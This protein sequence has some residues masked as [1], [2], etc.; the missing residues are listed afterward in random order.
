MYGVTEE[1]LATD[2]DTSS[3]DIP[4]NT[5]HLD[6]E[7]FEQLRQVIDPLSESENYGIDLYLQTLDFFRSLIRQNP[8]VT[9]DCHN[10]LVGNVPGDH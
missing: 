6:D 5:F 7:H 4:E 2:E 8:G 3:V 10:M 1:G 9:L